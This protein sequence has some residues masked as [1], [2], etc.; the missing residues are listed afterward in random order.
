MRNT[1]N[2]T[3]IHGALAAIL[4]LTLSACGGGGGNH[5][6]TTPPPTT[7]PPA[8][9][10]PPPPPDE[11]PVVSALALSTKEST[12]I[13]GQVTATDPT[14]EALT[15]AVAANPTNGTLVSFSTSGAFV[16]RPTPAF[17]GDDSF[18]VQVTDT[19]GNTV[20]GTVTINV[21]P[22][23]PPVAKNDVMRA[24]GTALA[25]INL[26]AN[27]TD[28]DADTLTTTIVEAPFVGTATVNPD[29]TVSISALPGDFK[30]VTRFKYRVTDSS[31][32]SADATAA[33]FVGTEPFRVVFAGDQTA[34]G[35]TEVFMSNFVTDATA[36]TSA[37][38]GSM[39]LRGFATSENAS[40]IVYRR[41]DQTTPSKVDLSFVRTGA[42]NQKEV[43]PLPA[44]ATLPLDSNNQ[45]QFIVSPNG[46]W[47]ALI[48]R[49]SNADGV[50]VLNV[51]SPA[52]LTKVSPADTLMASRLRFSRD[53][54]NLY[55]LASNVAGT[56]RTLYTVTPASPSAAVP[57]SA[58]SE[59]GTADDVVAYSISPDQAAILVQANRHGK[60]GLFFVDARQLQTEV[61]V[62]HT[63]AFGESIT[64]STL[65]LPGGTIG[66]SLGGRVGYTTVQSPGG[67]SKVYVAN[68]SSTPDAH[69]V[70]S[71]GAQVV[72]LRPDDAAVLYSKAGQIYEQALAAGS[73]STLVAVGGTAWYDSTG[74]IVLVQQFVGAAGYPVLAVT[75]RG[76]FGTTVQ[77]GTPMQAARLMEV[78]GFDRG[79]AVMAEGPPG[80]SAPAHA[81]LALV[82]ALAP[83]KLLYLSD[84]DS[85]L[86]LTSATA[87]VVSN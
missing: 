64:E 40:T 31:G 49:V 56:G 83:D 84:F 10:P 57:V 24:D 48:A 70:A 26:L 22:N 37:T 21:H 20:M 58:I 42:T 61:Q 41:E 7:P 43:V 51:A 34:N 13:S 86:Q 79:V 75:T 15:F 39:R 3:S 33:V 29:S 38:E 60:V 53:S 65:T 30:G 27:D 16:Y 47:I 80:T 11:P 25:S 68:V 52:T 54:K 71:G 32:A 76:S 77:V 78:S 4:I 44:G 2:R 35:S 67:A 72:G 85:P 73:S 17:T 9:P 1:A 18:R 81:R 69:E 62:N 63:L 59:P 46:K 14:G 23:S 74:N 55:F 45:D 8:P 66:G 36:V 82:N 50:Y 6:P 12:D 28:A 19:G 5:T 87:R